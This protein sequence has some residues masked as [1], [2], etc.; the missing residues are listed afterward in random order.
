[1]FQADHPK[2]VLVGVPGCLIVLPERIRV[3]KHFTQ[4]MVFP[5]VEPEDG[6]HRTGGHQDPKGVVELGP[7]A[8][9]PDLIEENLD[10]LSKAFLLM[11]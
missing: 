1:V 5:I 2:N 4:S 10:E 9:D 3:H 11:V 7:N 8:G 6:D